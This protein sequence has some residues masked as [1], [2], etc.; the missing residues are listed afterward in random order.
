VLAR[1]KPRLV[2]SSG[3]RRPLAPVDLVLTAD[4]DLGRVTSTLVRAMAA[5][6]AAVSG[7][8]RAAEH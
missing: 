5:R 2:V 4:P 3:L 6:N 1:L 7:R 8:D